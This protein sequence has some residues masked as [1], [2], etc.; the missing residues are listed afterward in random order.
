[1]A[2]ERRRAVPSCASTSRKSPAERVPNKSLR[3][4]MDSSRRTDS[5]S[6]LPRCIQGPSVCDCVCTCATAWVYVSSPGH[7]TAFLAEKRRKKRM[8]GVEN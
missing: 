5:A 1:M 8:A 6:V 2:A 3:D 4:R 7:M